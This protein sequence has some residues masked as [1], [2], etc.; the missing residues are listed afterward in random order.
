MLRQMNGRCAHAHPSDRGLAAAS[1]AAHLATEY[2]V[3]MHAIAH[4]RSRSGSSNLVA[5][6]FAGHA[7]HPAGAEHGQDRMQDED[8]HGKGA[9]RFRAGLLVTDGQY[10]EALEFVRHNYRMAGYS[11]PD[12]LAPAGVDALTGVARRHQKIIGTL[13]VWRD[14]AAGLQADE[15]YA[16][17]L[18]RLRARGER[19]GEL[20]RLAMDSKTPALTLLLSLVGKVVGGA[21]ER[22]HLTH[23]VIECNPR[24]VGFYTRALGF[25]VIGGKRECALVSAPAVLLHVSAGHLLHVTHQFGRVPRIKNVRAEAGAAG[26]GGQEGFRRDQSP[27]SGGA[28]L[29]ALCLGMSGFDDGAAECHAA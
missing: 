10:A 18:D 12:S 25:S 5:S 15:I 23:L 4:H 1:A 14:G 6:R 19:I 21:C 7:P 29:A 11:S 20:G 9:M 13:S 3:N 8:W 22:W 17:E 27:P 16:E 24:H 28:S 26:P 2:K